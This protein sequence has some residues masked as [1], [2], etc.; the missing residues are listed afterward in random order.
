[1]GGADR[2]GLLFFAWQNGYTPAAT[3]LMVFMGSKYQSPEAPPA[4]IRHYLEQVDVE[5]SDASI[6]VRLRG[7]KQQ[8]ELGWSPQVSDGAYITLFF[9]WQSRDLSLYDDT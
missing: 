1:M 8:F 5:I 3:G 2:C 4:I 9:V 6:G 7:R